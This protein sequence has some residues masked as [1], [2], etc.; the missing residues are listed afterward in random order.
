MSSGDGQKTVSV[1]FMDAAGNRSR[2]YSASITLDT[3]AP[4]IT[5]VRS[6]VTTTGATITWN[7]DEPAGSRVEFGTVRTSLNSVAGATAFSSSDAASPA[8]DVSTRAIIVTPVPTSQLRTSHSVTITGLRPSTTYYYQVVSV[9]AAGNV[10]VQSG[11]VYHGVDDA[12]DS[13]GDS[14]GDASGDPSG[15]SAGDTASHSTFRH[16]QRQLGGRR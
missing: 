5:N 11:F 14:A 13:A 8:G 6:S 15:D 4:R 7:T 9:D 1:E 3:R 2:T 16:S 12:G 10:A